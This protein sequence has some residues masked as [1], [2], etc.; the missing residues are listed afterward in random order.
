[1]PSLAL[2]FAFFVGTGTATPAVFRPLL[3]QVA[4]VL[5]LS[6]GLATFDRLELGISALLA[7]S[8]LALC[9][10]AVR[11]RVSWEPREEDALLAFAVLAALLAMVAP[12]SVS[13][14]GSSI[15]DRLSLFPVYGVALW[16]GGTPIRR[17]QAKLASAAWILVAL[18]FFAVRL[19]TTLDLS[20]A[21]Q[22][23]VSVSPCIAEEA[24]MIQVNLSR[25]PSGSLARAEDFTHE[26]SRIAAVTRGHDLG[27]FE[28][29]FPFF[30][31]HNRVENDPFRY[32]VTSAYGF[33]EVPPGVDL[34]AY[35]LRPHGEVDYVIVFGQPQ[36][37]AAT[38][39]SPAWSTLSG[40]LVADFRLVAVSSRGLARVYEATGTQA[41]AAGT[42][43]RA[44]TSDAVCHPPPTP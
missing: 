29:L 2:G 22:E 26:A 19:P 16:L 12:F 40:E 21:A 1:M 14:G 20:N 11:A 41:A 24:T 37:T 36:A 15:P 33:E 34:R 17:R 23:Y 31:F 30:L 3:L 6:L 39:A 38:L 35:A 27:S 18:A 4:G 42:T 9:I 8:L 5:S 43:R 25:Y 7:L 10:A 13:S 28:G 44:A 32:I